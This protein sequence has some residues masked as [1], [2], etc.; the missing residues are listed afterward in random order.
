MMPLDRV[1]YTIKVYKKQ[2]DYTATWQ[3]VKC[4]GIRNELPCA[5]LDSAVTVA[6]ESIEKHH[7]QYHKSA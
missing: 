6:Q 3:C 7:D 1:T 4:V 2:E 5:D